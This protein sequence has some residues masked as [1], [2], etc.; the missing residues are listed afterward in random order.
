MSWLSEAEL[1]AYEG[2]ILVREYDP[3][4]DH[5]KYQGFTLVL[6]LD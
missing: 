4:R 1:K 2:Y 3:N 6:W 5:Q